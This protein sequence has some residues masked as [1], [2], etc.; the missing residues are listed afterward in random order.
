MSSVLSRWPTL[1]DEVGLPVAQW[2]GRQYAVPMHKMDVDFSDPVVFSYY[3]RR[4]F[5]PLVRRARRAFPWNEMTAQDMVQDC[6]MEFLRRYQHW[7]LTP[8]HPRQFWWFLRKMLARHQGW[9]LKQE[10]ENP[11]LH[12]VSLDYVMEQHIDEE[13]FWLDQHAAPLATQGAAEPSL[14]ELVQQCE[15]VIQ[16][17]P[18]RYRRVLQLAVQGYSSAEIGVVLGI[19]GTGVHQVVRSAQKRLVRA[20]YQR[21]YQHRAVLAAM[22]RYWQVGACVQCGVVAVLSSDGR[23]A[24][25]LAQLGQGNQQGCKACG[26][27]GPLPKRGLCN[28]CYL[29]WQ[30]RHRGQHV[31]SECGQVGPVNSHQR[32]AA[33]VQR[34]Q[35]QPC[36]TCGVTGVPK[37]KGQCRPCA[38]A[39][40]KKVERARRKAVRVFK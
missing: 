38:R 40:R 26:V 10:S 33:C 35:Q 21:G 1:E 16:E 8:M 34:I 19:P 18:E 36:T 17:Q 39:A 13:H 2:M 14:V 23:C 4:Y 3:Y 25:C 30:T 11:T 22:R 9:T 29:R 27:L 6:F 37:I 15:A 20:M 12:P 24:A 28:R 7:G 32:C 5:T 31:C